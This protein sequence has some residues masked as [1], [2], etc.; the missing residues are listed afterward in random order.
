M[1]IKPDDSLTGPVVRDKE[2]NL[3]NNLLWPLLLHSQ[4]KP[5][6]VLEP[7]PIALSH[8]VFD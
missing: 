2:P 1:S 7:C 8:V 5:N 3:E 6:V 4:H